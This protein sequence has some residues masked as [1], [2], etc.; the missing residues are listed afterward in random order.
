MSFWI[1]YEIAS[2]YLRIFKNSEYVF[3]LFICYNF[4]F[5]LLIK[6]IVLL[7]LRSIVR[8]FAQNK[9]DKKRVEKALSE[10]GLPTGKMDTISQ[11]KFQFEDFFAFYK[12][13]TQRS[14]VQ[15]IFNNL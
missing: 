9:E 11:S 6:F 5:M 14:E 12:S 8:V 7:L 4:M 2:R 15:K 13:L 1:Q 10:S 3:D